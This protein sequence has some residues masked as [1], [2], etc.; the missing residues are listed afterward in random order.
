MSTQCCSVVNMSDSRP[1]VLTVANGKGGVGK[2]S[3]SSAVAAGSAARGISTLYVDL[4][5]QG[6][7]A[8]DL[9]VYE[10]DAGRGLGAAVAYGM[11]LQ[12]VS[13]RENLAYSPGG[14]GTAS[15]HAVLAQREASQGP[16]GLL[17]L[18]EVLW[19]LPFDLVV[20]DT[21]PAQSNQPVIDAALIASD[22]LLI[23][24]RH[25]AASVLGIAG[26]V[27]RLQEVSSRKFSHAQALGVVV[28]CLSS[29]SKALRASVLEEL[30]AGLGE[31]PV[32][33]TVIRSSERAAYDLR[34]RGQLATEY[35]A[36]AK[37][38]KSARLK[39]LRS[40]NTGDVQ[41]FA[42]GA[43]ELAADYEALTLEVLTGMGFGRA[44]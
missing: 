40:G 37:L 43:A 16:A 3:V 7:S 30:Q 42:N 26:V 25:D 29:S 24:T 33:S 20:I 36:A 19:S 15:L 31:I 5:P 27:G 14:E 2:T 22:W 21:P 39:A 28:F 41:P 9:G 23:P 32:L 1:V 11:P 17:A 13:A 8:L 34:D 10:H 12:T 4:D 6:N 18:R 35:A 44:A 38:A